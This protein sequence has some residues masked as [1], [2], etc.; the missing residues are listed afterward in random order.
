MKKK[1]GS[2]KDKRKWIYVIVI[3]VLIQ[4]FSYQENWVEK[5]YSTGLYPFFSPI[6]RF[7]FGW[8]PF[9]LGDVL[10]TI[11]VCWLLYKIGKNLIF[12]IRK[13][14]TRKIFLQKI[15]NGIWWL[16]CV[17]IVFSL[18]WGINYGR[19]GIAYQLQL[20]DLNYDTADVRQVQS[21]IINQINAS[22]TKILAQHIEYP[23]DRQLFL[24]AKNSYENVRKIYPF[25]NY[26]VESVKSSL[27]DGVD[28][29]LNIGGYYNPFTGEAQV[30]TTGPKFIHPFTT[31][32]EMAHQL[33]YAKENEANFVGFLAAINSNNELFRYG[34]YLNLY[35][36]T[37]NDLYSFDSVASRKS[38]ELL[39]P[40]VQK[41]IMELQEFNLA[42]Q[43]FLEPIS[44]WI[45]SKYLK[46]NQ[47]PAGMRSYNEVVAMLIAYYK[48]V[49][50]L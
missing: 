33:G 22:K 23:S 1:K 39:I 40:S 44:I 2:W 27:Y 16:L 4:F 28:N 8:I 34:T 26:N 31:T 18:F 38:L 10:Y 25:L 17:Y 47:Q 13:K 24:E 15:G 42:H 7:L 20:G 45:Y 30:N 35:F 19:K 3:I 46:F 49:G 50:K 36:Y 41:D 9:S 48:K 14:I 37:N 6:L 12:W 43:S 29:Y 32:H 11:A 5:Y 21:I